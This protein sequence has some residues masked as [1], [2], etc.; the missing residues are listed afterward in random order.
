M[1]RRSIRSEAVKF[2]YAKALNESFTFSDFMLY[3]TKIKKDNEKEDLELLMNGILMIEQKLED[4]IQ[5]CS[6]D[7]DKLNKL[8]I[9]II[10][11]GAFELLY[12]N[13]PKSIVINEAVEIAK[14]FGDD[15][16]KAVVNAIL[17]CIGKRYER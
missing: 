8:D 9:S 7:Y 13:L 6:N 11:V 14:K 5:E 17:E 2:L 4:F 3:L 12:T 10:K 1:S 15:V 16:T